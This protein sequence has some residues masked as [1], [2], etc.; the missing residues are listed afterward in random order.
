MGLMVS[1]QGDDNSEDMLWDNF[2]SIPTSPVVV[3]SHHL[4]HLLMIFR[5]IIQTDSPVQMW[6]ALPDIPQDHNTGTIDEDMESRPDIEAL[7]QMDFPSP[8]FHPLQDFSDGDSEENVEMNTANFNPQ[9]GPPSPSESTVN[10][11]M[12]PEEPMEG[13]FIDENE[14]M[15]QLWPEQ[16]SAPN[17]SETHVNLCPP[18]V[19][20]CRP[21]PVGSE[22]GYLQIDLC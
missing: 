7:E 17:L 21:L 3:S 1:C 22:M 6:D 19:D 8:N 20:L 15:S 4:L 13:E 10:M 5:F 16:V 11:L 12:H 18:Q 9:H 14:E 2:S